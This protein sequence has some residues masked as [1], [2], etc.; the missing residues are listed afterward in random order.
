MK[1][2]PLIE[3]TKL[4]DEQIRLGFEL[5]LSSSLSVKPNEGLLLV[6]FDESFRPYVDI[7]SEVLVE[8]NINADFKF[9]P[10]KYQLMLTEKLKTEDLPESLKISFEQPTAALCFLSGWTE[11]Q[12]LRQAI[13]GNLRQNKHCRLAHVPGLTDDILEVV[14]RTDFDSIVDDC[15]LM[16]WVLGNG[17]Q[18]SIETSDSRGIKYLLHLDL[19]GWTNEPL[20]SPG[21][22]EKGS[23]G[24]FPPAE[25]FCC[26]RR[27]LVSGE[28]CINGSIPGVVLNN[29]EEIVL[30]FVS[31][32]LVEWNTLHPEGAARVARFFEDQKRIAEKEGDENWN[33]FCE[34]GIG[35]NHAITHLTG[36]SLFDEK[37]A[38]TIHI[39]I[40]GNTI[41]GHPIKSNVHFDLVTKN[42]SLLID[43]LVVIKE[44]NILSRE[45]RQYREEWRPKKADITEDKMLRINPSEVIEINGMLYRRLRAGGRLGSVAMANCMVAEQ[46]AALY[47]DIC[48]KPV[49]YGDLVNG[50]EHKD[51]LNIMDL[52][53]YLWHYRAL[54]IS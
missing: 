6:I 51:D 40:G 39:A 31:G 42:P 27:D 18:A 21:I 33:S 12:S 52:V 37:I 22:I 35:L 17:E 47:R 53:S 36:N 13:V 29:N 50:I 30:K 16:A 9:I 49:R 34:L 14:S 48:E 10:Q 45:L 11:G 43:D 32:R 46:L 2:L 24:N 41:F 4:T 23:W 19:G 3:P 44:G 20:M 54:L 5:M 1:T 28:I 7:F 38:Q 25:T 15:E 8:F 26:P